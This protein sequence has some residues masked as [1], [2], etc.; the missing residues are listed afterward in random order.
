[1]LD[2]EIKL[3]I[4]IPVYNSEEFLEKCINSLLAQTIKNFEIILINDG[5]K[6]KSLEICRQFAQIDNRIKVFNQANS[7]QSK[8]RNVGIENA[9]GEYITFVDSD[10]WVDADYYEKLVD[11]SERN[12]ADIACA[13]ILRVRK[14]SQKYRI[15]Y[16]KETIFTEPQSKIDAARVPDMCYVWNKVY[17]RSLIDKLELRFIKGMFF[18]DVDFVTRAVFF[19]NKI[20]TVPNTYYHYWTNGN[21]TVK[22]MHKSDKK[23]RD[24]L[25]SKQYVLEFFRKYNLTSRSRNLIKRKNC[26]KFFGFTLLKIY[27]WETRKEYYLFGFIPILEKISYA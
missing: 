7:G 9:A 8:A 27:E 17:K 3:S 19:S 23:R 14:H 1:M 24:S 16:T 13:S 25:M 10:D 21:S 15:K 4:I 12:D 22:T 20:V 26:I 18:E 6:D 11:A 2:K 5:S